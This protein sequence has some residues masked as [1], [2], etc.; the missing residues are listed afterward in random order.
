MKKSELKVAAVD[1]IPKWGSLDLNIDNLAQAVE[2]VAE[3]SVDYAVFPETALSG[4][5]FSDSKEL[6]LF[7]DTIAGKTTDKILPLLKVNPYLNKT[8]YF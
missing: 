7:L 1:F 2:K 6:A 3:Q 8:L 5:L 4:Y